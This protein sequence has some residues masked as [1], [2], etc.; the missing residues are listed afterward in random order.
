MAAKERKKIKALLKTT[1]MDGIQGNTSGRTH[2][3][4]RCANDLIEDEY[5][6][7]SCRLEF[8]TKAEGKRI[9]ILYP[10][11]G[12]FYTRHWW[13]GIGDAI[14][15]AIL[16]VLVVVAL[17]HAL[18]GGKDSAGPL[19]F[20]TVLLAYEKSVSVY[21]SNHFIKEYIPVEKEIKSL[22]ATR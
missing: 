22:I 11:G 20:Y 21:D 17:V 16:L 3:C 8:K 1:P 6:C 12:Y 7:P 9:S 19:V 2:L 18:Q 15:E 10:G 14:T 4:P 5:I 13:L